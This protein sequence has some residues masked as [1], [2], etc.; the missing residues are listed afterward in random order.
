MAIQCSLCKERPK[1]R[2]LLCVRHVQQLRDLLDPHNQ[3]RPEQDVAAS[4]PVLWA[5]LDATPTSGRSTQPRA[6]GYHSAPA[7][8]LSVVAMRDSR[9]RDEVLPVASTLTDI[10]KRVNSMMEAFNPIGPWRANGQ[11]FGGDPVRAICAYL[12]YR[13]DELLTYCHIGDVLIELLELSD[14]LREAVGDAPLAPA[15]KCIDIIKGREC[16]GALTLLPP[17]PDPESREDRNKVPVAKCPRCY[18]KYTWLDLVRV[19]Y[20]QKP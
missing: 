9:T 18:R 13:V 15:G 17:S 7:A 20:I 4:V 16:R 10:M 3:G 5:K 11:W 6:P 14:Q 12:T 1:S 8:D 2:S 19:Q